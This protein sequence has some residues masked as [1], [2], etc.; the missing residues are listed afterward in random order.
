MNS[1]AEIVHKQ[2]EGIMLRITPTEL[3][4]ENHQRHLGLL[5]VLVY[6]DLFKVRAFRQLGYLLLTRNHPAR[7]FPYLLQ[8]SDHTA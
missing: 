7:R 5:V 2:I 4:H 1:V 6:L 8:P 3:S